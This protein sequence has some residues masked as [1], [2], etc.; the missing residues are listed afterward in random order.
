MLTIY[1]DIMLWT[2]AHEQ[3]AHGLQSIGVAN[4]TLFVTLVGLANSDSKHSEVSSSPILTDSSYLRVAQM[5]RCGDLAI[6]V[7][8]TDNRIALPLARVCGVKTD[9]FTPCACAWDNDYM[10][11]CEPP[12]Y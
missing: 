6:F 9:C 5:S 12:N 3:M 2:C 10:C 11:N 7:M 4:K 8:T 1:T